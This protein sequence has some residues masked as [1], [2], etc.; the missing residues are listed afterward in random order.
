M[1]INGCSLRWKRS[2]SDCVGG[3]YVFVRF[4]CNRAWQAT[5]DPFLIGSFSYQS[6]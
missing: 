4:L 6:F 1:M 2:E 3:D 5:Y